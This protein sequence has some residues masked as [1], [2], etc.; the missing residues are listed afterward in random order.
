M[1]KSSQEQIDLDEKKII[2]ELEKNAKNS[3]DKIAKNCGCS[4]QKV[5][6][7]MKRLEKNKTAWGYTAII[8]KEKLGLKQYFILIKRT[9]KAAPKEKLDLVIGRNLKKES[10]KIGVE[11]VSSYFVHGSFDWHLH[12]TVN[13]ILQVK[14]FINIFNSLFAEDYISDI[15][16]LEV[17]FPVEK[18]GIINPN[19][20]EL[21]DF[22]EV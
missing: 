10:A 18:N 13:N 2:R 14:Q 11:V 9:S 12:I 19:I 1:P 8:D 20:K 22:F 7:I 16:V 5:W 17:I 3:I 6:R 15:Q 21:E 4:R